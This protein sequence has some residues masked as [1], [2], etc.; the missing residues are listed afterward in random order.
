[1]TLAD[2]LPSDPRSSPTPKVERL[3]VKC[4]SVQSLAALNSHQKLLTI[5]I[6][7]T[8]TVLISRSCQ[9][10]LPDRP[11]VWLGRP[12][13]MHIPTTTTTLLTHEEDVPSEICY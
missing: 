7:R 4:Y 12:R 8:V 9:G 5:N 10:L 2:R 3:A 6:T 1:M 11:L 13:P